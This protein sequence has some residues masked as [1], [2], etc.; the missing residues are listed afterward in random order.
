MIFVQLVVELVVEIEVRLGFRVMTERV[1]VRQRRVVLLEA[2][3]EVRV[4][5]QIAEDLEQT[6]TFG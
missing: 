4:A 2:L 6:K 1:R 3:Q 5:K